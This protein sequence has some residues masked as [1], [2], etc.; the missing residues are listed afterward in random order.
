M[1]N[2][3]FNQS[4]PKRFLVTFVGGSL[5]IIMMCVI[6]A[7]TWSTISFVNKESQ[8]ALISHQQI[9]QSF[10]GQYPS[11]AEEMWTGNLDS[12]ASR[13][14][15]IADQL[16]HADYELFLANVRGN[17]I[18]HSKR[19][20]TSKTCS[21]PPQIEA[22]AQEK[23]KA[24]GFNPVLHFDE[25]SRRNIYITPL[26]VGN[27]LKG[28]MYV[29]LS[30][31]YEFYRGSPIEMGLQNLLPIML[32]VLTLWSIWLLFSRQ[33]I[34][35]PYLRE[36]SELERQQAFAHI[37]QQ[38]AHDIKSLLGTL[39]TTIHTLKNIPEEKNRI[40]QGVVTSI[41]EIA[42][43]LLQK[44]SNP[45]ETDSK[46]SVKIAVQPIA[47]LI[48][49]SVLE[50]KGQ[51]GSDI[52]INFITSESQLSFCAAIDG[53]E[54]KRVLSNLLDNAI[55]ALGKIGKV[56]LTLSKS[57]GNLMISIADNGCGIP[58][59]VLPRLGQRG[60]TYGKATGSGLG[61]YHAVNTVKSWNGDLKIESK[62]GQGTKVTISLPCFE[63]PDWVCSE[64]V[65]SKD[66]QVLILDDD[67]L[68]HRS[69]DERF[70]K[71]SSDGPV[72]KLVH[73]SKPDELVEYFRSNVPDSDKVTLLSDYSLGIGK[74]TGLAVIKQ[75]GLEKR[76][77]L[78]TGHSSEKR[79]QESCQ[80]MGVTLLPKDFLAHV[81]I[82]MQN[83]V[84]A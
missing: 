27:L 1:I 12:I 25:K 70:R 47:Q 41:R 40:I 57:Q 55:E 58:E 34:L 66:S 61:L 17:C 83:A 20:I 36:I 49:E 29:S 23:L 46:I 35:N 54:F 9:S 32:V 8:R 78:V 15:D 13:V 39:L 2:K 75:L 77:I 79:I 42:N 60:A 18:Y 65:I 44:P 56:A 3:V 28:F 84:N 68:I 5:I 64:V 31:P 80:K 37:T 30:D 19:K 69:W 16:G 38:V 53:I 4:G 76:S 11:I 6:I 14:S 33:Y 48:E 51:G 10:Q 45:N 71:L 50:K 63:K 67:T 59:D 24:A 21:S 74:M 7:S 22:L 62:V 52:H 43:G 82:T 73:F 81:P 72:P 26:F